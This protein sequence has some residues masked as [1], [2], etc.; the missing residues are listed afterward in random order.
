MQISKCRC[1]GITEMKH[2]SVVYSNKFM[3]IVKKRYKGLISIKDAAELANISRTCL[4][5]REKDCKKYMDEMN[6]N[7]HKL[8]RIKRGDWNVDD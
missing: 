7:Q 8:Q 3:E 4:L 6:K 5:I 2:G 1:P